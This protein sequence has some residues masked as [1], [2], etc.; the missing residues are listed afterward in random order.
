MASTKAPLPPPVQ[1][2]FDP[3]F[4]QGACE[5]DNLI[6]TTDADQPAMRGWTTTRGSLAC[7][8]WDHTPTIV[9]QHNDIGNTYHNLADFWRIWL[10]MAIVQQVGKVAHW[11]G[12]LRSAC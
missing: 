2:N 8:A 7:D 10:A 11:G 6:L 5:P 12:E 1:R 3:G 4:L 9:I